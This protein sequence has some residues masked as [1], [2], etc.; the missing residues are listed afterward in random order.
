MSA[1]FAF[2]PSSSMIEVILLLLVLPARCLLGTSQLSSF[3]SIPILLRVSSF[4]WIGRLCSEAP[5]L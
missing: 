3:P 2:L 1:T 5:L 4:S